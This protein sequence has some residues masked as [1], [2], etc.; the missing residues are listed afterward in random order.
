MN[1]L[2]ILFSLLVV[3]FFMRMAPILLSAKI[4]K[5]FKKQK[6]IDKMPKKPPREKIIDKRVG[7]YVDYEEIEDA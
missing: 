2:V 3:Y 7:E 1:I 5:M 4:N 6:P